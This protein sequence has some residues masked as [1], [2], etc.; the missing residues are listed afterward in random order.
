LCSQIAATFSDDGKHVICG[1]ED[2]KTFVW[3]LTG[4]DAL[5]QD[6]DKSPCEYFVAH[7]D[8]VTTPTVPRV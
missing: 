5:V 2:R 4:G 7:G 1:S 3:S 8:I 6:K